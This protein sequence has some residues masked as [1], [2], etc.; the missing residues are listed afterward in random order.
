MLVKKYSINC[1]PSHVNKIINK[2]SV[3]NL[4]KKVKFIIYYY[5]HFAAQKE[6]NFE[7]RFVS[8]TV[9][10]FCSKDNPRKRDRECVLVSF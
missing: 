6:R 4:I 9:L 2:N 10:S 8:R 1:L 7:S 5:K 3:V